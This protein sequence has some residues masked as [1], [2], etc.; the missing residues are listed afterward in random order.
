MSLLGL[1]DVSLD[2]SQ[3]TWY[4]KY[5]SQEN[6]PAPES[7]LLNLD[8]EPDLIHGFESLFDGNS[9]DGWTPRGGKCEFAVAEG[10]IV[11]TCVPG[12]ASTYLCT[13]KDSFG[14][15][16]F[17]CDMFWKVDGN[18]GIMFRSRVKSGKKGREIV[19]GPQV[20]MEGFSQDRGWSGGIY[21]QS[22]GGYFY[23]LWLQEHKTV[24]SALKKNKWNRV[25]IKARGN[26]VQT[27]VNG[28]P[29]AHWVDDGSYP[30][31][32]F[33]LQIHKGQTGTVLW[34]NLK[35]KQLK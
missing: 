30:S 15:F 7:M 33:G 6:A 16:I 24:R 34:K 8:P 4:E 28:V 21:G 23:P 11:G 27:W 12:S 2:P 31:G 26:T 18:T 9:L 32:F 13:V 14:D 25:T 29:A 17:T 19:Y 5:K 35:V 1:D 3:K 20:E 22:C 10:C